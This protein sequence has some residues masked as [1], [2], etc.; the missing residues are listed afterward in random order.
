[1]LM[2]KIATFLVLAFSFLPSTL[3]WTVLRTS[4]DVSLLLASSSAAAAADADAHADAHAGHHQYISRRRFC[5]QVLFHA[6]AGLAIA[7]AHPFAVHAQ[8]AE[9]QNLGTQTPAVRPEDPPFTTL[10]NGVK[11]ADFKIGQGEPVPDSKPVNVSIQCNGRLLN[12]NGVSFYN[13]KNNNPD[14]FGAIPLT[15]PMNSGVALPGL[16]AGMVGMRKGGIRRIVVPSELAYSKYPN[17]EPQPTTDLERRALDSVIKNPR[18]DATI[19]FDVKLERF[20]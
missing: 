20:K 10:S 8:P 5:R 12:L 17:L 13:T 4:K 7:T 16:E 9:F 2:F 19:L 3:A 15:F 18:R 11:I 14:G 1:M 6:A